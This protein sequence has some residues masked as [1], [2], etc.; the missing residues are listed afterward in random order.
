MFFPLFNNGTRIISKENFSTKHYGTMARTY[1]ATSTITSVES[2]LMMLKSLDFS[3]EDFTS[4]KEFICGG[5]RIPRNVRDFL[6]P[7]LPH[8]S[9]NVAYGSTEA[10][11]ITS[12]ENFDDTSD[13][14]DN[15]I[16]GLRSNVQC[17]VVDIES[18]KALGIDEVGEI[19]VKAE[20]MFS[21]RIEI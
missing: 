9:F 13:K 5:E 3:P 19:Y 2:V 12:F 14:N 8:G 18:R 16:G 21:V 1:K 7:Q 4:M 20:K 10:G 17:M 6:K 15:V 11:V